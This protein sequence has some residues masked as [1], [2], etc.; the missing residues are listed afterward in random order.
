MIH[1]IISISSETFFPSAVPV[2]ST[3]LS[4]PETLSSLGQTISKDAFITSESPTS[5]WTECD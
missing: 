5:S 3:Q 4:F 2:E 1:E